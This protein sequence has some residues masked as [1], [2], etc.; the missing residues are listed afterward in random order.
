MRTVDVAVQTILPPHCKW[1]WRVC[2]IGMSWEAD[3]MTLGVGCFTRSKGAWGDTWRV[4]CEHTSAT[5]IGWAKKELKWWGKY[6]REELY[7]FN[8]NHLRTRCK[9]P[10]ETRI[11]RSI[12][13]IALGQG[14]CRYLECFEDVI[15]TGAKTYTEARGLCVVRIY[16]DG[17]IQEEAG[18]RR[19]K[20]GYMA[21]KSW[22]PGLTV[23]VITTWKALHV[24][25]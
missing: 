9:S 12:P 24:L 1:T 25:V 5:T 22:E 14:Y 3:S 6:M 20:Q 18:T 13:V 16:A 17:H 11:M 23:S 8:S 19:R 4:V 21:L 10:W 2:I 15:N 7:S